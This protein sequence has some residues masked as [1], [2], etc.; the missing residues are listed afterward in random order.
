M[1]K[2][3]RRAPTTCLGAPACGNAER[4]KRYRLFHTRDKLQVDET[5]GGAAAGAVR[6]VSTIANFCNRRFS[7][8]SI[9]PLLSGLQ[10]QI[11]PPVD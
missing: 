2:S 11:Y 5:F 8:G 6:S 4:P 9:N 10:P 1:T 3:G 7:K